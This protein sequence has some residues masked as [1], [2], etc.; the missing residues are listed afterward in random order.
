MDD[1]PAPFPSDG[2]APSSSD[3]LASVELDDVLARRTPP[4]RRALQTALVTAA[5]VLVAGVVVHGSL[6]T[7]PTLPFAAHPVATSTPSHRWT[8]TFSQY[9][10]WTSTSSQGS[11]QII[12]ATTLPMVTITSNVTFGVLTLN[13]HRLPDPP[14]EPVMLS[15][16][17]NTII[18]DATPFQPVKCTLGGVTATT[19]LSSLNVS[20]PCG[21]SASSSESTSSSGSVLQ[22]QIQ[23]LVTGDDLPPD[24]RD[25]ALAT[26]RQ[27]V[28]QTPMQRTT[29]PVGQH[30]ATGLDANG[31]ILSQRAT[32]PLIAELSVAPYIPAAVGEGPLFGGVPF[33][34]CPELQCGGPALDHATPG[35]VWFVGEDVTTVW[36]FTTASGDLAG[37]V[38]L[39]SS[40]LFIFALT[41]DPSGG[42]R[43]AEGGSLPDPQMW[44]PN[45]LDQCSAAARLLG[46]LLSSGVRSFSSGVEGCQLQANSGTFIWRFGVLLA[47]DAQA[48][49]MLPALP[50]ASP[51]EISAVAGGT[52]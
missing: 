12:P 2:E 39:P 28:R 33:L 27:A 23:I 47:A 3:G 4:R 38:T 24:L 30:Y 50:I 46:G 15:S 22:V 36:R 32:Q 8:S 42:W 40:R 1:A 21:L 14:P 10:G 26:V 48:H 43:L 35:T 19:S 9:S 52:P 13:G 51:A 25:S 44:P 17:A 49:T 11:V 31:M 41:F 20:A 5:F 6:T 34:E 18:L 29:V 37:T 16:T 7:L 45:T